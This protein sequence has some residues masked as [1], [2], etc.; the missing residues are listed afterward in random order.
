MRLLHLSAGKM[1]GGVEALQV[2]LAR[3]MNL[4]PN[5]Q[6]EFGVAFSGKLSQELLAAGAKVHLLG[7][8]RISN[9]ASVLRCWKRILP[10]LKKGQFD[11]AVCHMPWALAVFGIPLR[12][13]RVRIIFWSHTATEGKHWLERIASLY[14]PVLAVCPSKFTRE[15]M[16]NIFSEARTP[17]VTIYYPVAQPDDRPAERAAIRA[18]L[19]TS[20]DSVVIIQATRIDGLKGHRVHFRALAELRNDK[21]W[22][23]WVVGG[24]QTP[25]ESEY[26]KFITQEAR[27]L[28]I[29]DRIRFAGQRN[30]VP[31]LLAA[32]D[33]YCQP[34]I[35]NEGLPIVF[36]EAMYAGLP[37]VST[38]ICGFWEAIDDTCGFLVEPN[39][40]ER[41]AKALQNLIRDESLRRR[42]GM[43]ARRRAHS[44]FDVHTQMNQLYKYIR[45]CS[46]KIPVDAL[47]K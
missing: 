15:T 1:F 14:S 9:A 29:Y 43:S 11:Y 12:V 24:P 5:M 25:E 28:G 10:I 33:I 26:L 39:D 30:D 44:L 6:P 27:Q 19:D 46:E 31:R 38:K 4:C 47:V 18:E 22:T 34:N 13:M 8:V 42:L 16:R 35:A 37:V 32:A 21:S 41:L 40:S 23:V 3:N 7:D 45:A 17:A 2:T 36:A 20:P